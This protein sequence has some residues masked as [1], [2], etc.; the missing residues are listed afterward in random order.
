MTSGDAVVNVDVKV[1]PSPLPATSVMPAPTVSVNVVLSGSG[2]LT[3]VIVTTRSP[4]DMLTVAVT[5]PASVRNWS[6]DSLSVARAT[7][8]ENLTLT[9]V[10]G[11]ISV[12]PAGGLTST[13]VGGTTSRTA[14]VSEAA[15]PWLPAPSRARASRVKLPP[16]GGSD[17]KSMVNVS[18]RDGAAGLIGRVSL[19]F[20]APAALSAISVTP[21]LS[22]ALTVT[23]SGVRGST[24]VPGAGLVICT[25]GP[26]ESTTCTDRS[27]EALTLPAGSVAVTLNVI[28]PGVASSGTASV[29]LT[30]AG[31]TAGEIVRLSPPPTA[32][33]AVKA[34]RLTATS[35]VACTLSVTLWPRRTWAPSA[36]DTIVIVG[37]VWSRRGSRCPRRR[38][39]GR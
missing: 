15:V 11:S 30:A 1:W 32:P 5:A 18:V 17:A 14:S 34:I 28:V 25:P 16:A 9:V 10:F 23:L 27:A 2:R 13:T 26:I 33:V 36:G 3:G 21:T 7:A 37:A 35:S 4:S 20:A 24:R 6:V 29:K 38:A 19:V 12:A 39:R 31:V 8:S 22:V